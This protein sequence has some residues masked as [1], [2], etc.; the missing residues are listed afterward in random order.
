MGVSGGDCDLVT[1]RAGHPMLGQ[2]PHREAGDLEPLLLASP[3][4]H[5]W[6]T[7]AGFAVIQLSHR[8]LRHIY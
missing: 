1:R 3:V 8:D 4:A 2:Q 5:R 6:T 7:A